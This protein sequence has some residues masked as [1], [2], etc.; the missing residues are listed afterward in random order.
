MSTNIA[1]RIGVVVLVLENALSYIQLIKLWD[2][3][4]YCL[5]LIRDT[6]SK[7]FLKGQLQWQKFFAHMKAYWS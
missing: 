5:S 4:F 7:E 2:T 1:Q 6:L 3:A